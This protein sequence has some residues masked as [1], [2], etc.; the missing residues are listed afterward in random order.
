MS[1]LQANYDLPIASTSSF[2]YAISNPPTKLND[3]SKG[4]WGLRREEG[5]GTEGGGQEVR[6]GGVKGGGGEARN[7][8]RNFTMRPY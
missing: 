5:E 8:N 2:C 6:G 3:Y 4:G 7:K 1:V